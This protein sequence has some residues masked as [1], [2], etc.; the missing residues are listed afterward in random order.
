MTQRVKCLPDEPPISVQ[1]QNPCRNAERDPGTE[2]MKTGG[3]GTLRMASLALERSGSGEIL[4]Q[5]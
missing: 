3:P 5:S 4:V 2:E 1:S